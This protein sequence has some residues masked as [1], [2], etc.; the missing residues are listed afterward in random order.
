[1]YPYADQLQDFVDAIAAGRRPLVT[2]EDGRAGIEMAVAADL[3]AAT[4]QAVEL[5]LSSRR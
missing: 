3:A 4:N 2:G 5:P 1:M